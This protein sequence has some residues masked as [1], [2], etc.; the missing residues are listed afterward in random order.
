MNENNP[1]TWSLATWALGLGMAFAGGIVNFIVRV[2][3]GHARMYNFV[4]LFGEVFISGFVG[5]GSYMLILSLDKPVGLA[6][7]AAGIGG[8]MGTRLLVLAERRLVKKYAVKEEKELGTGDH[9]H[10]S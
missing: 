3:E 9:N 1:V 8:H 2:K 5:V 4:E 10:G 6:A 7:A